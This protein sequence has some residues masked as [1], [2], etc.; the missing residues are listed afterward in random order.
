M[1]RNEDQN[2]DRKIEIGVYKKIF[3]TKKSESKGASDKKKFEHY[4]LT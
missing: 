1:H 3:D 2:A 4:I